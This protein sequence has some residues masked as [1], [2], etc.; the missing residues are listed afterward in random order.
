LRYQGKISAWNADR[1]F[2]FIVWNGGGEKIFAHISNFSSKKRLP[3]IGDVVTYELGPVDAKGQKAINVQFADSRPTPATQDSNKTNKSAYGF[4]SIISVLL[5]AG[6]LY[7]WFV[8][9]QAEPEKI[10]LHDQAN[11]LAEPAKSAFTAS[12]FSCKGK[13]H[14]SQ[15]TSCDEATFYIQN[16]PNTEMDGDSDGIPC[17]SQWCQ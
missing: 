3:E 4:A 10:S 11:S 5:I 16:C 14:C 17:E 9:R 8:V 15:M 1:G 2:G 13:I 7:W 12:R 6:G